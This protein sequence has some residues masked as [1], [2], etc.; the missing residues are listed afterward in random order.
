MAIGVEVSL[1]MEAGP[2]FD[3]KLRASIPVKPD[4]GADG[5]TIWNENGTSTDSCVPPKEH[6]LELKEQ[7]SQEY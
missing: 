4:G 2:E 3:G 1:V 7:L 5:R 6:T